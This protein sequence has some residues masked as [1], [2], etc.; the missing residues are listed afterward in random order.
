V[1]AAVTTIAVSAVVLVSME[2][3]NQEGREAH[4]ESAWSS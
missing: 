3:I 1:R 4:E 2:N